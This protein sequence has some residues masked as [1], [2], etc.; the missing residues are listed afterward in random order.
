VK[1]AAGQTTVPQCRH[2]AD[3]VPA[4]SFLAS[5]ILNADHGGWQLQLDLEA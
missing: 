4:V 2:G 3:Q 5:Q 1:G